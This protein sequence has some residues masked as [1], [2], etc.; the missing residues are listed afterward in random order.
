MLR[1]SQLLLSLTLFICSNLSAAQVARPIPDGGGPTRVGMQVFVLDI[2]EINS[3]SQ[4]FTA[5]VFYKATWNDP[6]LAHDGENEVLYSLD[7][8]WHP[9]LQLSNQQ[10]VW[11]TFPELVQVAPNG[12]VS[13]LQR[14]WGP[15]S[16]PMELQ[17]F[18]FD[19]QQLDIIIVAPGYR[20][21]SVLLEP[22]EGGISTIADTFSVADWRIASYQGD[23]YDYY[24]IAGGKGVSAF[25][26]SMTAEREEGYYFVVVILP[27]ILIVAMS[28][29]VFWMEPEVRG[30]Q[31][32]IVMTAM[33]T[34][35]A[36]RF[37]VAHDLP[38]ISYLTRMDIFT[39]VTTVMVFGSMVQVVHVS[40]LAGL[41]CMEEARAWN[42]RM[43]LIFPLVLAAAGIYAFVL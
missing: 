22:L 10:K 13:Y 41:G 17:E 43:R 21:D 8:V 40:R 7:E 29:V 37:A 15:F 14:V 20:P 34:L 3:A 24:P 27:L 31:F 42:R 16:Q 18:P 38:K 19:D 39:L 9:R 25:R 11:P 23:T 2:D 1:L 36:Y 28:W 33:L 12:D 4:N 32:S 30:S 5:N 35:I 6:R 26:F